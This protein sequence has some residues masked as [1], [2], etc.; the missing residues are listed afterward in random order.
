IKSVAAIDGL[1]QLL[2]FRSPTQ[3]DTSDHDTTPLER[4]PAAGAPYKIGKPAP[5]APVNVIET[6]EGNSLPTNKSL[7][8]LLNIFNDDRVEGLLYLHQAAEKATSSEA[9]QR[10]MDAA[11][12]A[13]KYIH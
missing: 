9:T 10:L 3:R 8:A 12:S 5:P 4:Y 6:N 1:V 2:T 11:E 13:K 7:F